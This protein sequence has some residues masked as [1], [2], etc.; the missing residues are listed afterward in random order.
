M[1]PIPEK[2]PS[3][4][5][6]EIPFLIRDA[7]TDYSYGKPPS[8]RTIDELLDSSV[9]VVDKPCGPSSHEVT[10]WVG[11]ILGVKKTGHGGTLDP[12]VS[13]VLVV[14]LNRATKAM[15]FFSKSEKEYVGIMRF[16]RE[17]SEESV[18]LL[19]QKFTGEIDQLPPVKSAVKRRVRTRKINALEL[20]E[21]HGRDVLFR[22]ECE[23][24]T[25]I[26][27]L[28]HDIGKE[29]GG[30]H[31]VELR[32]TRAGS[33]S[34]KNCV[35]LHTLS[36][37]YW[38]WK[39]KGDEKM[40]RKFLIPLESALNLPKLYINDGA[41]DAICS[42]AQ[43]AAPGVVGGDRFKKNS[44]IAITTLKGELVAV[45]L[46]LEDI[47]TIAKMEKGYVAKTLR[48]FMKEGTYLRVWGRR[49][50]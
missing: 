16:H 8:E 14:G 20:V 25:Y 35:T 50:E 43:L 41:V 13:G 23:A 10:K 18:R 22:V 9:V 37:A 45:A 34:E 30:A 11:K 33:F 40:L 49:R 12:N 1:S 27:K 42:G 38:L 21:M 44:I 4:N 26:R 29:V 36:D 19:F 32:R 17:I 48:V 5:F 47:E 31:M 46:A 7:K 6:L 2:N 39:E 24:G 3:A 28:C 15:V